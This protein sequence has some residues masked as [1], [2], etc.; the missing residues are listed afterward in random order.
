LIEEIYNYK[1]RDKIS[2][3]YWFLFFKNP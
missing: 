3:R 2:L 1:R